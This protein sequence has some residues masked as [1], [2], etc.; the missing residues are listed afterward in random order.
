MAAGPIRSI[1]I[2]NSFVSNVI[3]ETDRTKLVEFYNR[4]NLPDSLYNIEN[5]ESSHL[6]VSFERYKESLLENGTMERRIA[7]VVMG[8][9]A[10]FS[11]GG[12]ELTYKL[13][14]RGSKLFGFILGNPKR[15]RELLKDAYVIRSSF[16]H[17]DILSKKQTNKLQ[18]KYGENLKN[19]LLEM[20]DILRI[21]I[22]IYIQFDKTKSDLI[23]LIDNALIDSSDNNRLEQELLLFKKLI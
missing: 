13:S 23:S 16:A 6:K 22:I 17:G 19:I 10:L 2:H 11:E 9:E 3:R 18:F 7:T 4:I 20:A 12:A 21:T 5:K 1:H 14:T 15:Y 8:M